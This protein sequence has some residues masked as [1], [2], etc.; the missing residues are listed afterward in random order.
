ME[1]KEFLTELKTNG[2]SDEL[3]EEYYKI[4]EELNPD[5][6]NHP[7]IKD[8]IKVVNDL[9]YDTRIQDIINHIVGC[10]LNKGVEIPCMGGCSDDCVFHDLEEKNS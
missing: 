1:L 8:F 9:P 2:I 10:M 7:V 5:D 6:F 3:T 4:F